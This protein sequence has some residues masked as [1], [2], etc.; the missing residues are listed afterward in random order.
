MD[1]NECIEKLTKLGWVAK[2]CANF[3]SIGIRAYKPDTNETMRMG[4]GGELYIRDDDGWMYQ[5]G[6]IED[7]KTQI[8]E[9]GLKP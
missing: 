7:V 8:I 4:S 1:L 5:I 9:K 2:P 6:T 3:E